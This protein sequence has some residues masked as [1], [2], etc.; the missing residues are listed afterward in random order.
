MFEYRSG[1]FL[2]PELKIFLDNLVK[3]AYNVLMKMKNKMRQE[4]TEAENTLLVEYYHTLTLNAL[5]AI[6]PG[7]DRLEIDKQANFLK[8]KNRNFKIK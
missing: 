8:R 5:L 6:F 4:W 1:E 2:K 7:R 3:T